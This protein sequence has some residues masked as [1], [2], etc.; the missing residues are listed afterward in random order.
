MFHP[1]ALSAGIVVPV[2]FEKIDSTP[3]AE[4]RAKG[5]DEGLEG[6]DSACEKCHK[7]IWNRNADIVVFGH[8]S[9]NL[10]EFGNYDTRY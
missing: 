6:R 9:P 8:S 3:H 7:V 4:A 2:P 1:L 5:D 10:A